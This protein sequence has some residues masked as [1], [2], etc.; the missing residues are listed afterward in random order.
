MS[1]WGDHHWDVLFN[2]HLDL[3]PLNLNNIMGKIQDGRLE[4][5]CVPCRFVTLVSQTEDIC[6]SVRQFLL[7]IDPLVFTPFV[8]CGDL[9]SASIP[10]PFL[11]ADCCQASIIHHLPASHLSI[12]CLTPIHHPTL[13]VHLPII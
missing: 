12:A 3:N 10:T 13:E 5:V 11:S 2:C 9:Q 1:L 7:L 4:G 6:F 8:C